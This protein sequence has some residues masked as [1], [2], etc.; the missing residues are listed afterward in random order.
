M[1]DEAGSEGRAGGENT[2]GI[3]VAF[4]KSKKNDKT[5]TKNDINNDEEKEKIIKMSRDIKPLRE[6]QHVC[7]EEKLINFEKEMKA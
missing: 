3:Y 2:K 6:E 7:G 5:Q 1:L 4:A